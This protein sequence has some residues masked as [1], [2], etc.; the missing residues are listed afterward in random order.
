MT[1]AEWLTCADPADL[2]EWLGERATN[3]KA[4]LFAVA[5]FRHD[6]TSW[7]DPRE[8]RAVLTVERI[9]DGFA[10]EADR[11]AAEKALVAL[12]DELEDLGD[13]ECIPHVPAT[14]LRP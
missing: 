1:E 13:L 11:M 8:R 14:V 4:R 3:R 2:L 10:T 6:W 5:C 9:A 12:T 7:T